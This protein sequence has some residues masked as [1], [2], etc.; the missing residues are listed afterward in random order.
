MKIRMEDIEE[1][2][3]FY[4]SKASD[5][6]HQLGIAGVVIIWV[7]HTTNYSEPTSSKWLTVSAFILFVITIT[8]SLIHYF[9]LAL[10]ADKDFHRN[11]R[12]LNPKNDKS[13]S[14]IRE[15]EVLENPKLES[16]SWLYFKLKMTT[17]VLAYVLTILFVILN[18]MNF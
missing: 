15:E 6:C 9:N 14:E 4:S 17:L 10:M 5:Y 3:G 2:I 1:S 13:L 12:A 8:V 7:L 11:E 18:L 16:R